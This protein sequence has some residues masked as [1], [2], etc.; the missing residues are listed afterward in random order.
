M[1]RNSMCAVQPG[2]WQCVG[3]FPIQPGNAK[4]RRVRRWAVALESSDNSIG[5]V[6]AAS[7]LPALLTAATVLHQ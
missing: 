1:C 4:R 2:I 3:S 6:L 7:R 5:L